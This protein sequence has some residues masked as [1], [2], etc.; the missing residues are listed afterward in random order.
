MLFKIE[1][2]QFLRLSINA[3]FTP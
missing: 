3:V 2:E 1:K